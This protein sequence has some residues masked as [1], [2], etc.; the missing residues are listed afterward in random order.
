MSQPGEPLR[1]VPATTP[2]A[3]PVVTPVPI[4][5]DSAA[6]AH[7]DDLQMQEAVLAQLLDIIEEAGR[8]VADAAPTWVEP[9]V[10]GD[11]HEG[12]R[13]ARHT[14]RAQKRVHQALDLALE[15]L[16]QHHGALATFRDEV[17]R[18]E[19]TTVEQLAAV[20]ARVEGTRP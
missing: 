4:I 18:V 14:T 15:A 12:R 10:F 5:D 17:R 9:D 2:A 3:T 6:R 11:T 20:R 16:A 7:L 13:M 8:Q 19:A 1:S